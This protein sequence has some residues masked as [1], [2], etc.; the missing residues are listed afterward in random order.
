M[1]VSIPELLALLAFVFVGGV[2]PV[3]A[4]YRGLVPGRPAS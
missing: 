3:V 1:F 2:M 4:S